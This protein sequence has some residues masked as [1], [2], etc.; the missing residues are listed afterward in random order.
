MLKKI[1]KCVTMIPITK[2]KCDMCTIGYIKQYDRYQRDK[3]SYDVYH[4][5][6]WQKLT[7]ACK[8]R[9]NGI[10][11]YAYYKYGKTIQGE[12]S[13]HIVEVK[14]DARKVFDLDNLIYVSNK[15][16]TE[17]HNIYDSG[18]N[19][20]IMIQQELIRYIN[21]YGEGVL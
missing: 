3:S 17:I 14:E 9:F 4:H 5:P 20:K 13:H 15:S 11:V 18:I 6:Q 1:C 7:Q 2:S 12:L 10:D 8:G 19:N 16:H 21:M